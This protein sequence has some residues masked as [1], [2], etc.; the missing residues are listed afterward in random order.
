MELFSAFT[1]MGR[2]TLEAEH[3]AKFYGD[4]RVIAD[5][6][7]IFLQNERIG[8]VGPNGY[9]KSTLVK[10]L[11]GELEPDSGKVDFGITVKFGYFA[12]E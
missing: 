3:V 4:K 1:R 7:Y 12:Q 8:I 11:T 6:S 9:G 10:M 2:K 5:F